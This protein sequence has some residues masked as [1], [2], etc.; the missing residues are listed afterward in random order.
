MATTLMPLDPAVDPSR[1][2]RLLDIAANLLPDEIVAGRRARHARVGV[3]IALVAVVAGLGGWYGHARSR[4]S[5]A[6]QDLAGVATQVTALQQSQ[7]RFQ[8]VVSV[9]SQ[10]RTIAAQLNTLL[11]NDLPWSRL[12]ATL[13][14]TGAD[15][16]VTVS[17]VT[18][19]LTN[20][21][22]TTGA[23]MLPNATGV[24]TVGTVTVTGTGPDKPAIA[25]YVDALSRL[26]TVANPYLTTASQADNEVMFSVTVDVTS[27]ALCGRYSTTKCKSTGGK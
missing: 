22:T 18:G 12:L 25:K 15:S 17:G 20:A 6:R 2:A 1:V 26:T 9:Q 13:R 10:T 4:V 21:S 24:T 11:A 16:G 19:T 3:L 5:G 27:K 8:S 23:A 7:T 14:D